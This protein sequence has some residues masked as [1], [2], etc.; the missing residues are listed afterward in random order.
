MHYTNKEQLITSL[1][2]GF[3]PSRKE[4]CKAIFEKIIDKGVNIGP[5]LSMVVFMLRHGIPY[6]PAI[7]LEKLYEYLENIPYEKITVSSSSSDYEADM[8]TAIS[9]Y[10]LQNNKRLF[11]DLFI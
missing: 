4:A 3:K 5:M 9:L 11:R 10:F 6:N 2:V 8:L 1:L 7:F